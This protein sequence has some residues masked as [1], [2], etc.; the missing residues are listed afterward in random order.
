MIRASPQR[1]SSSPQTY[2]SAR[3][4]SLSILEPRV[5]GGGVVHDEVGDHAH[6]ALVRLVDELPEVLDGAVVREDREKVRDVVAAVAQRRRVHR[7]QPDAVDA[8][9][10]QIVELLDQAAEVARAVVVAVEEAAQVDL[11]ED[12]GLEPVRLALEPVGG[13][14]LAHVR[15]VQTAVSD[16]VTEL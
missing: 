7:Q 5:V 9:P 3:G 12:G 11:V 4:L 6:P 8:E 1:W 16:T 10:L 2:Q 15:P 14:G 13:S